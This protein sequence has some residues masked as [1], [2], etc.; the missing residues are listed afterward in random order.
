[1]S[2]SRAWFEHPITQQMLSDLKEGEDVILQE[3]ASGAYTRED[4]T[5]TIQANARAIG[6]VQEI[7]ILKSYIE[8]KKNGI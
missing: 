4:G 2:E 3:W 5:A 6:A 8:E 7:R 1:M